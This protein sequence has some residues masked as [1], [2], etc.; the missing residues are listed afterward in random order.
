M[1]KI[2]EKYKNALPFS[3]QERDIDLLLIELFHICP[4]FSYQFMAQIGLTGAI[5]ESAHRSVYSKHGE[6]DVLVIVTHNEKRVAVMIEDKIGAPMQPKQCERY[7]LRGKALCDAKKADEYKTIL[8]APK[9]YLSNVSG[10]E[11]WD[12]RISFEDVANLISQ[13]PFFG[14]EWKEAVLMVATQKAT[15]AHEADDKSNAAYNSYL[16]SL[17]SSYYDFLKKNFPDLNGTT[18]QKGRDREYYIKGN[19]FPSG[20]RFKHAFFRG[21]VSAIFEDKWFS[22]SGIKK[23]ELKNFLSNNQSEEVWLEEHKKEIHLKAE[24]EV[25][26]PILPFDQQHDVVSQALERIVVSLIPLTQSFIEFAPKQ[27]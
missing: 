2:A 14:W 19:N 1:N 7:H 22:K 26:D 25:M 16:V 10:N 15:R 27:N 13:N 20:I 9:N 21:Q 23:E 12:Y 4:E 3:V 24:V 17:K 5:I 6:T 11:N 8:F 18:E